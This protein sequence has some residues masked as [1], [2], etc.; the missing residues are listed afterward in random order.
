M[1]SSLPATT[2]VRSGGPATA[3]QSAGVDQTRRPLPRL[4]ASTESRCST[5]MWSGSSVTVCGVPPRRSCQRAA[6]SAMGPLVLIQFHRSGN[7]FQTPVLTS[8]V[9]ATAPATSQPAPALPEPS[10]KDSQAALIRE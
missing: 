1:T 10:G 2:T 3:A 4:S 8:T 6:G 7:G 5:T 9:S